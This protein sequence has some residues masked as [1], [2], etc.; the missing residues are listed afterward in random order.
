MVA[1]GRMAATVAQ[2]PD[3]MGDLGVR[4]AV[5]ILDGQSVPKNV[6][7]GTLVVNKDNVL[8]FQL[9]SKAP[10]AAK[11]YNISV[12]TGSLDNPFWITAKEGAEKAAKDLGVTVTVLGVDVEGDSAKQVAQLED[13]IAKKDAAIVI[14]VQDTKALIPAIEQANKAGIP[15]IAID[16]SAEGGKLASVIM[17]NN[18][19]GAGLGAKMVADKIGGKGKVLVL[20]GVPG[21]QTAND[22]KA[23]ALAVLKNYPDIKVISLPG[24]WQTA[25]AQSVVEDVLTANPDLAGIFASNDMMAI[26]AQTALTARNLADKVTLVGYDAIPPALEMVKD[27]RM[28]ATVAQFPGKMGAMGVE[29][30]VRAIQGEK[31]PATVDSGTMLVTKDNVDLFS[32]GVYGK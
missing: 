10:T 9:R 6:D 15:V 12:L 8:E 22:R 20:E 29:Y 16:K 14:A 1:D 28:G 19:V 13:R 30:A 4:F 2:F 18:I 3:K 31:V 17:T 7:S 26:G 24:D 21:G 11:P 5:R 32:G 27:G 23:G 25:K